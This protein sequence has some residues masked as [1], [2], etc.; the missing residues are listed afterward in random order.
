MAGARDHWRKFAGEGR[1]AAVRAVAEL[2]TALKA[3]RQ[4]FTP[5]PS[6]AAPAGVGTADRANKSSSRAG[7]RALD[8]RIVGI[9]TNMR[10]ALEQAKERFE[11]PKPREALPKG[12][13]LRSEALPEPAYLRSRAGDRLP[14]RE[15]VV[16]RKLREALRR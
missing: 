12:R 9:T 16:I 8:D 6:A 7:S 2:G 11:T 1:V 14:D 5:A 4:R 3:D 15:T 13:R 10:K